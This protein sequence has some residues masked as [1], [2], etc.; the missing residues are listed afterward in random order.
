MAGPDLDLIRRIEFLKAVVVISSD[1][2]NEPAVITET[3][4]EATRCNEVES[5]Y[6]PLAPK[7]WCRA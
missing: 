3:G 2:T 6:R 1:P 7:E 4:K 5:F